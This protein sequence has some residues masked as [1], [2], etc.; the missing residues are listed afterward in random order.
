MSEDSKDIVYTSKCGKVTVREHPGPMCQRCKKHADE[1]L[2]YK[3]HD[4]LCDRCVVVMLMSYPDH[5]ESE[6]IRAAIPNVPYLEHALKGYDL[7]MMSG[8][9]IENLMLDIRY[10]RT[11]KSKWA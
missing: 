6:H 8:D 5:P 2:E 10:F 11:T 9:D 4:D 7:T 1:R 3:M